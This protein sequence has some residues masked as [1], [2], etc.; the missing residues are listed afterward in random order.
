MG[1]TPRTL[2]RRLA[3]ADFSFQDVLDATRRELAQ[4][5][6][7]DPAL[8]ALDVALLL[9]YAEQSSFT[10]AFRAWFGTTPTAWR[11]TSPA[12]NPQKG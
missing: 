4:V 7:R 5:Y 8:S 6:L 1:V 2:Q 10:R 12:T 11:S 9:G 3:S